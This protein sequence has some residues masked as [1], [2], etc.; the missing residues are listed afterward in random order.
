ML[1]NN[2]KYIEPGVQGR[3]QGRQWDD[4]DAFSLLS[5]SQAPLAVP[6]NGI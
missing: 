4:T 2:S 5:R 1:K 3:V 6:H